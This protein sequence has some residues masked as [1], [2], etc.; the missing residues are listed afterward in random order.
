M[1]VTQALH[2]TLQQQPGDMMTIFADRVRTVAESAER[3]SRLAGALREVGTGPGE[4]VGILALNSDRYHESLLAVPWAG[5]VVVPINTR[6]S[7]DEIAYA[8]RDSGTHVLLVDNEFVSMLPELR[9]RRV[10]L[11]TVIYCG[12]VGVPDGALDYERLIEAAD[13]VPDARRGGTDLFGV[14]YTGGTTGQPK[15]VMLSHDN[16]LISALGTLAGGDF[17]SPLGRYLHAAPMFHLAD[18]VGWIGGMLVGSTHV[19]VPAFTP[20][21]VLSAVSQHR[22]TDCLLVPTMLQ[23]VVDSPELAEH[24]LSS[25]RN[26]V[27]GA[28][29]VSESLLERAQKAFPEAGLMQAYGMTELS[30]VATVLSQSDHREPGLRRAAGRAAPHSEVR[31]TD[32]EDREVPRGTVGEIAVR[33]DHVM[34]G[35]LNLPDETARALR[36]GWMHTG[37]AGYMDERGYVFLV[38]RIKDMIITGGENVY[39]AE[40]ENVLAKHPAVASCAVIGVPDAVLG[41]RVHAVVVLQPGRSAS[42]EELRGLCRDHIARYKTPRSVEFTDALPVSGAG[43]VLKRALRARHVTDGQAEGGTD[44]GDT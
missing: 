6:W 5:D 26:I 12:D 43:K 4:R 22:V 15:G 42:E 37:D 40:V 2:R 34:V 27:Y 44:D 39:S 14:F 41:E 7:A 30:P 3:V 24:D 31:I 16:V 9:Q 17:V 13:S 32:D 25:V 8:L 18:I 11:S 36:D 23:M 20:D 19:I 29:P 28:S 35:Y 10:D 38:D 33:G 21:G 1:Y